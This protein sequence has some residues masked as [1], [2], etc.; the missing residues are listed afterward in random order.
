V[1]KFSD[2]SRLIARGGNEIYRE[3]DELNITKIDRPG[4]GGER[5]NLIF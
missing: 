5:I 3:E 1:D 2:E 4:Y